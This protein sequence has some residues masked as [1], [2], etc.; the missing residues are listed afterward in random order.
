MP[1]AMSTVMAL[2]IFIE[3]NLVRRAMKPG[4]RPVPGND[5]NRMTCIVVPNVRR[6]IVINRI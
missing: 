1:V 2:P 6:N 5:Q 3:P 4:E